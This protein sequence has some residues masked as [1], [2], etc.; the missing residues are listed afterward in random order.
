MQTSAS[1]SP[2]RPARRAGMGVWSPEY[3]NE[4]PPL[5]RATAASARDIGSKYDD[6]RTPGRCRVTHRP[7]SRPPRCPQEKHNKEEPHPMRV[8][9]RLTAASSLLVAAL[10]ALAV[11]SAAA[12]AASP[13][14]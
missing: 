8:L 9:T 5:R 13:V 3:Q 7:P 10:A 14:V 1:R 11:S 12:S 2:S 6:S 4:T